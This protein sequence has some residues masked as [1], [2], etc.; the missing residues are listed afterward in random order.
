MANQDDQSAVKKT[1]YAALGLPSQIAS[2]L[3]EGMSNLSET[4]AET[5][6]KL[7]AQLEKS[8]DEWKAEGEKVTKSVMDKV[9]DTTEVATDKAKE[10]M[11]TAKEKVKT[12]GDIAEGAAATVTEPIVP[13]DMIDGV[14][15][16][17]ADELTKAGI[18]STIALVERC[19]SPEAIER[20]AE[21]TGIGAGLIENWVKDAD[22]TRVSGVGAETMATLNQFGVG[23]V[24]SLA[25]QSASDLRS[26]ME[27]DEDYDG[28]VPSEKTLTSYINSAKGLR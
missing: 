25:A 15:P 9:K 11:E 7:M 13:V 20:L 28:P 3:R 24:K 1:A 17:Y 16:S 18:V 27:A 19:D 6:E 23:T 12:G 22:L 8:V 10:V 4:S 14:G 2:K 21:Q 26:K 5:R